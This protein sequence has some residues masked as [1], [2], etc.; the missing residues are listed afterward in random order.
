VCVQAREPINAWVPLYLHAEHWKLVLP[1]LPSALGS[2]VM[3]DPLGY[4]S[5][6]IN[7]L[8][9]LLGTMAS[10]MKAPVRVRA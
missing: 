2:L 10:S 1:Q 9:S 5:N 4:N 8:F 6:Q 7:V 3:L